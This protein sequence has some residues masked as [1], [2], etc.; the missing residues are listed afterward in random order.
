MG[1]L[2][3]QYSQNPEGYV[4]DRQKW[5]TYPKTYLFLRH[6][7]QIYSEVTGKTLKTLTSDGEE[8]ILSEIRMTLHYDWEQ[9][10][11]IYAKTMAEWTGV[12]L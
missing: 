10:H 6:L 4:F 1:S 7:K 3:S 12:I 8:A 9:I 5:E 11:Y 2:I